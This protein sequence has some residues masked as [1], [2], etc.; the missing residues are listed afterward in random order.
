[1]RRIIRPSVEKPQLPE[2]PEWMLPKELTRRQRRLQERQAK[3]GTLPGLKKTK[4]QAIKAWRK[5]MR[6]KYTLEERTAYI[7]GKLKHQRR[8]KEGMAAQR[9]LEAMVRLERAQANKPLAPVS[10]SFGKCP[11][12]P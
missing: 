3:N 7:Q 9:K 6:Q 5:K 2:R 1:M 12:D 10:R 11:D 4:K 8:V